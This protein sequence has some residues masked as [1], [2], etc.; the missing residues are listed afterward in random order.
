MEARKLAEG[1]KALLDAAKNLKTGW[2]KKAD[3][4]AAAADYEKAATA[5]RVGKAIPRAID[6]FRRAAHAHVQFDS[7]FMA[8]K[9]METAAF[10][11]GAGGIK[12]PGQSAD[13]YE[14]AVLFHR[15]DGRV[16][17]AAEALGKAAKGLEADD[18]TRGVALASQACDL[19][20]EEAREPD[21]KELTLLAAIDAYK[22]AVPFMLRAKQCQAAARLL[23]RQA[24]MHARVDQPHNVARCE[25]SAVI[26]LLAADD[27]AAACAT[28]EQAQL[29]GEGFAGSDEAEAAAG[30]LGAFAAQDEE[31]VTAARS[32]QIINF[33]DNQVAVTARALTLRSVGVPRE[34]LATSSKG[35]S[36]GGESAAAAAALSLDAVSL[37]VGH[38]GGGMDSAA[39]AG[40][41]GTPA[42][43]QPVVPSGDF[44]EVAPEDEVLAEEEE[45]EFDLT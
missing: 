24:K 31:Q 2:F 22:L 39:A 20:D 43:A 18:P 7:G 33:L 34:L 8:A 11:A 3:H 1:E 26:A 35:S 14:E 40:S 27:Y 36:G 37:D 19:L 9:H 30:L 32:Q 45:E 29:T 42:S 10:L 12:D 6:A 23:R 38:N 25:L 13:L 28:C 5:F 41:G 16:A 15:Q 17:N 44:G 4:E 21:V